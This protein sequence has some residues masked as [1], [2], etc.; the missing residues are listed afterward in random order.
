MLVF[1]EKIIS[2]FKTAICGNMGFSNKPKRKKYSESIAN[3]IYVTLKVIL[4]FAILI[5]LFILFM[6]DN[7]ADEFINEIQN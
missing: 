3:V 7:V 5:C 4:L 6:I 1:A 2:I